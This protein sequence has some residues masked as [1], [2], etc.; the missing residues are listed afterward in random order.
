MIKIP[1]AY[2]KIPD[3][4]NCPLKQCIVFEKLDG[5]NLHW[6][7]EKDRWVAFGTRRSRFLFNDQG[8]REFIKRYPD[9]RTAPIIFDRV[10][11][12][13][14]GGY[15]GR[16]LELYTEFLGDHSFAGLHKDNETKR[17]VLIDA[18]VDGQMLAPHQFL[19]SFSKPPIETIEGSELLNE[20]YIAR[21]IY[22]G[23][24]SGRLVEDV[25]KG[26][27][28]VDEGVVIKGVVKDEIYRAKVKTDK[29]LQRLQNFFKDDWEKYWE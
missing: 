11:E 29:Y 5:T 19:K 2:P 3:T 10:Y 13:I 23:K 4:K 18:A 21:V 20:Y 15:F 24:Y 17:L 22:Q 27:Y 7:W 25:R 28:D 12:R 8:V 16:H 6:I 14:G 26:K 9:L 1:R